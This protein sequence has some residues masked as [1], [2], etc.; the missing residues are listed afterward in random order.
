MQVFVGIALFGSLG[1]IY[2]AEGLLGQMVTL[3]L[4]FDE[5]PDTFHRSCAILHSQQRGARPQF[6][7]GLPNTGSIVFGMKNIGAILV[8][9]KWHLLV[10]WTRFSPMTN[11]TGASFWVL[12]GHLCI[13][14]GEMSTKVSSPSSIGLYVF[15]LL[16][17]RSYTFWTLGPPQS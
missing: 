4:P 8:G 5:P 10:V 14:F 1:R 6:L 13:S 11:D 3:C 15:L 12:V 16:S 2:L 9:V 17:D 7:R